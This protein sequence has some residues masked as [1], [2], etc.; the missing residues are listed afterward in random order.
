MIS[1]L[2]RKLTYAS[3]HA[4]FNAG[5]S[6]IR[7]LCHIINR[8]VFDL[9][10]AIGAVKKQSG[11]LDDDFLSLG[12]MTEDEL[13]A[14]EGDGDEA[15]LSDEVLFQETDEDDLRSLFLKVCALS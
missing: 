3:E 11:R 13:E 7:C 14:H 2:T 1:A 10:E 5:D 6:T 15:E 8:G 9:L 12:E 4:W